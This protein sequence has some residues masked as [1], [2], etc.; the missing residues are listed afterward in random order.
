MAETVVAVSAVGIDRNVGVCR[1]DPILP[2]SCL[3]LFIGCGV[4][5]TQIKQMSAH[6]A[7][8]TVQIRRP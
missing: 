1:I 4:Q 5:P 7:S 3:V 2:N 8:R 6:V